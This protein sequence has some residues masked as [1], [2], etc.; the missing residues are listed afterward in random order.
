MLKFTRKFINYLVFT[1]TENMTPHYAK[2]PSQEIIDYPHCY[3]S[4]SVF[5]ISLFGLLTKQSIRIDPVEDL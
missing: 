3:N 5:C 1:D 4:S 2:N